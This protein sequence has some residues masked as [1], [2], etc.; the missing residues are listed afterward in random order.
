MKKIFI[1]TIAIIS[2]FS[3]KRKLSAAD[4]DME[5]KKALTQHLYKAMNYD[6][7]KVKYDVQEVTHFEDK[8]YY[9]C[10]FKVRVISANHDTTGIMTARISKDFSKVTRKS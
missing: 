4:L 5:L 8:T 1:L 2:V 3:C 7:S 10:Q 6:S 9:E